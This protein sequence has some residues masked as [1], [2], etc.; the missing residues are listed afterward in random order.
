MR[1]R[2]GSEWHLRLTKETT[3][4]VEN[5]SIVRDWCAQFEN[6]TVPDN[7]TDSDDEIVERPF[8]QM[9]TMMYIMKRHRDNLTDKNGNLVADPFTESHLPNISDVDPEAKKVLAVWVNTKSNTRCMLLRGECM[10]IGGKTLAEYVAEHGEL[11]DDDDEDEDEENG[12]EVPS[13][14]LPPRVPVCAARADAAAAA[15]AA[16]AGAVPLRPAGVVA[17]GRTRRPRRGPHRRAGGRAARRAG[18]VRAPR[19]RDPAP[20][21]AR[22]SVHC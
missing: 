17:A 16:A 2:G 1:L 13:R 18:R 9:D 14:R 7:V 5:S 21:R 20:P 15:A 12:G 8:L 3:E 4:A 11:S 22:A 19:R 10:G 6:M